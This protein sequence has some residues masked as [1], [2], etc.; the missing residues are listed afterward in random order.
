MGVN[1]PT[2]SPAGH[3]QFPS[4]PQKQ[5]KRQRITLCRSVAYVICII[6]AGNTDRKYVRSGL[7]RGRQRPGVFQGG[8]AQ[9]G[10]RGGGSSQTKSPAGSW[11]W[12]TCPTAAAVWKSGRRVD[13]TRNVLGV[14]PQTRFATLYGCGLGPSIRF[15]RVQNVVTSETPTFLFQWLRLSL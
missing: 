3:P 4:A 7:A 15:S 9:G 6:V 8:S 12:A 5:N 1:V 11:K 14:V 13:E 10:W 2:S